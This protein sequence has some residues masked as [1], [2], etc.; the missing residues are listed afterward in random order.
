MGSGGRSPAGP[1]SCH[2]EGVGWLEAVGASGDEEGTPRTVPAPSIPEAQAVGILLAGS[3]PGHMKPFLSLA[4]TGCRF[5]Q[6]GIGS[7]AWESSMCRRPLGLDLFPGP[8]R[9]GWCLGAGVCRV[10]APH[11]CLDCL[12]RTW[13]AA[14]R[15]QGPG[16]VPTTFLEHFLLP[17]SSGQD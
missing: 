7:F 2:E 9:G 13:V 15:L 14:G 11:C 10:L 4:C 1:G 6:C 12:S 17:C 16:L 5:R 8:G 3:L